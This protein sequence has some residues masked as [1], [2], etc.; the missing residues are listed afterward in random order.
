M[1]GKKV[2]LRDLKIAPTKLPDSDTEYAFILGPDGQGSIDANSD[3][4]FN[5]EREDGTVCTVCI[6]TDEQP[7]GEQTYVTA[8][9]MKIGNEVNLECFIGWNDGPEL[10][11]QKI[12]VKK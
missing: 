7:E 9:G 3:V 4:Y 8:M 10:R 1:I 12:N 11:V 2:V 5:V 6:K